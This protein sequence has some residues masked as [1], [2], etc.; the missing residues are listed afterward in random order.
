MT[1]KRYLVLA[2]SLVAPLGAAAAQI[3]PSSPDEPFNV[4]V[5]AAPPEDAD[6]KAFEQTHD[7]VEKRIK[8]RKS[9]FRLVESK[10]DADIVIEL[11]DLTQG[12][13]S[14]DELA[15]TPRVDR[16]SPSQTVPQTANFREP[17]KKSYTL[18]T[19]VHVPEGEPF[20]MRA[21]GDGRRPKN[22]AEPFAG[23]LERFVRLNYWTLMK[24]LG[25]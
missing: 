4:F 7:E 21:V 15:M 17:G 24:A 23:S 22:T 11:T 20:E 10:D 8:K 2:A 18:T 6:A 14:D 12:N 13:S 1:W 9:W 3:A 5:V 25:R 16:N 19:L